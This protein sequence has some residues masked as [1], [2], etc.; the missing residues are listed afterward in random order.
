MKRTM[1]CTTFALAA[2]ASGY[3]GSSTVTSRVS[4]VTRVAEEEG[5]PCFTKDH[6][7]G[8]MVS[9]G[10]GDLVCQPSNNV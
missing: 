5:D 10:H 3:V 2:F 9:G 4:K 8:Y 1:L 6:A 7:S